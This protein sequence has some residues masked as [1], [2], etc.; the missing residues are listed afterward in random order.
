[1]T[2]GTVIAVVVVVVVACAALRPLVRTYLAYRGVRVVTCPETGRPAAVEVDAVH[3]TASRAS[4][5]SPLLHLES[6]SRWPERQGCGQECLALV[7]AAPHDCL[8]RTLLER[9]YSG[10]ACVFCRRPFGEIHWDHRPTVRLPTGEIV[11]WPAIRAEELPAVLAASTPVCW[12]C[13]IA[14]MFRRE[15]PDL[16]VDD[17]PTH[18]HA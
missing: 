8:A 14:E 18:N 2:I 9:W 4:S 1:M 13:H 12:N 16:V 10:K 11:A 3:A 15:H 6:C 17:P 7:E 5:G